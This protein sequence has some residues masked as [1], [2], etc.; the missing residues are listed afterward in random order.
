MYSSDSSPSS[1]LIKQ[2]TLEG[3]SAVWLLTATG[4]RSAAAGETTVVW[5]M[6]MRF[7][8]VPLIASFLLIGFKVQ[9]QGTP[10]VSFRSTAVIHHSAADIQS[11]PVITGRANIPSDTRRPNW[12]KIYIYEYEMH[13]IW[14]IRHFKLTE[15]AAPPARWE[16]SSDPRSYLVFERCENVPAA[17]F[18]QFCRR[19]QH[20]RRPRGVN[21][22]QGTCE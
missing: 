8:N 10:L 22:D 11:N 14:L 4:G 18:V 19:R 7:V 9:S 6:I 1:D 17:V 21:R 12:N 16:K 20:S 2:K 5:C 15:S 13:L 3:K